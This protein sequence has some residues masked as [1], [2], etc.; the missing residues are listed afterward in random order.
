MLRAKLCRFGAGNSVRRLREAA[1]TSAALAPDVDHPLLRMDP[2]EPRTS[3]PGHAV[4]RRFGAV[5]VAAPPPRPPG[6]TRQLYPTAGR[7]FVAK[8]GVFLCGVR[9]V[10][11]K[12][13]AALSRAHSHHFA[14]FAGG[15]CGAIGSNRLMLREEGRIGVLPPQKLQSRW[16]LR[17]IEFLFIYFALPGFGFLGGLDIHLILIMQPRGVRA[18]A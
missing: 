3:A 15:S 8:V 16:A 4:R 2:T 10:G 12:H 11:G 5:L 6:E 7:M 14:L 18:L 17:A 9:A 1:F 13:E